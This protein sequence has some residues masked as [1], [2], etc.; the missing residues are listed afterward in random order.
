MPSA[1]PALAPLADCVRTN[2]WAFVQ[3]GPDSFG[4]PERT[5]RENHIKGLA[6]AIDKLAKRA[7]DGS[8]QYQQFEEVFGALHAAGFFPAGGLVSDV[9]KALDGFKL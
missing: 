1:P 8:V 3:D 4:P 2:S 7:A 9:V 6:D 5:R